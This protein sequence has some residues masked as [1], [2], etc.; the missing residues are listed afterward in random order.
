MSGNSVIG[1]REDS[2]KRLPSNHL[3]FVTSRG[4][5]LWVSI[6]SGGQSLAL[7]IR[8]NHVIGINI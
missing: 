3:T 4:L 8:Q 6:M 5:R 2:K 7:I 1:E